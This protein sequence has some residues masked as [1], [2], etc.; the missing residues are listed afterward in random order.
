[1]PAPRRAG[2]SVRAFSL[3]LTPFRP[4]SVW[5]Q[6]CGVPGDANEGTRAGLTGGL[7]AGCG[8]RP[9]A[10]FFLR[11]LACFAGAPTGSIALYFLV[12]GRR[13]R[14]V[15]EQPCRAGPRVSPA[16]S[17]MPVQCRASSQPSAG[18][19]APRSEL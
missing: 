11:F 9:T 12:R 16:C 14:L 8:K 1:M 10:R 6:V 15:F 7:R 2:P 13:E 19:A 5:I 3:F 4:P 18:G 17:R